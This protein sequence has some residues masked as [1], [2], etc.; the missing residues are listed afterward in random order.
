MD[1]KNIENLPPA[2]RFNGAAPARAR[3]AVLDY[4]MLA[5]VKPLQRGRAR[6]GADGLHGSKGVGRDI[7]AST[8][9]RPRGRGWHEISAECGPTCRSFNGARGWG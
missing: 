8:G 7:Y 6:A 2:Q 5:G 4:V 9:P 3:M 1:E